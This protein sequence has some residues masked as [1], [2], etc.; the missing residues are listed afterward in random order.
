MGAFNRV[1]IPWRDPQTNEVLN[2]KI[3]FKYGDAWQYDYNVGDVL[4]WGGN[5]IGERSAKRV[6]VDGVLE[7]YEV[8]PNVPEDFE[9][10]IV[11]GRIDKVIPATG[12]FNFVTAQETFIILER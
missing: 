9:V 7:D 11:E 4:A 5:D 10:H 12:S 1:H 3:Q 6:V 2:L 8:H